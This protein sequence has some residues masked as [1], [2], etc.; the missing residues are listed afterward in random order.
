L[1]TKLVE[2]FYNVFVT[3]SELWREIGRQLQEIRERKGWR[4]PID[5]HKAG[6]GVPNYATVAKHERGQFKTFT[7]LVE[8]AKVLGVSVVDV[9]S[10]AMERSKRPLNPEAAT[11]LRHFEQMSVP[12][13]QILVTMARRLYEQQDERTNT[14][15]G[16][17]AHAPPSRSKTDLPKRAPRKP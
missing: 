8:H 11:L 4:N 9:L 1:R 12:D 16:D 3:D 5:V 2:T 17:G 7:S 15:D 14:Q 10:A 13:R 6:A